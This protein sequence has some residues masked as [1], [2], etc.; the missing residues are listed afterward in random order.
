LT[1][2]DASG[3]FSDNNG[4]SVTVQAMQAYIGFLPRRLDNQDGFLPRSPTS[5]SAWTINMAR[6]SVNSFQ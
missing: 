2:L 3:G 6:A 1:N 5:R 4:S